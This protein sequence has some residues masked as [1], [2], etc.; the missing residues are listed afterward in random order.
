MLIV[1][2]QLVDSTSVHPSD[3][4]G[5]ATIIIEMQLLDATILHPSINMANNH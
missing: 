4:P 3:I 2:M 5:H 1:G